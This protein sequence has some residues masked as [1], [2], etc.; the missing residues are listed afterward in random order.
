MFQPA[1]DPYVCG[2]GVTAASSGHNFGRVAVTA[3]IVREERHV[4]AR[5]V[6][7]SIPLPAPSNDLSQTRQRADDTAAPTALLQADGPRGKDGQQIPGP[8]TQPAPLPPDSQDVDVPAPLDDE[9]D[10]LPMGGGAASASRIHGALSLTSKA[11]EEAT[12]PDKKEDFGL[13]TFSVLPLSHIKI[14][15]AK[16]AFSVKAVVEM[17]IKIQVRASKGPDGQTDIE[18]DADPAINRDNYTAVAWD[19][20]PY[21][22]NPKG[23]SPCTHFWARDLTL[24]HERFHATED[25]KFAREGTSQTQSWLN[26]QT[27][28]DSDAVT[29]LLNQAPDMVNR[30]VMSNMAEREQRAYANGAAEYQA[31]ADA[32]KAKGDSGKYLPPSP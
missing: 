21:H 1:R 24:K 5:E 6:A 18:S 13:T 8:T 15:R 11:T 9:T 3:P 16:G 23:P 4:L 27:A 32:I 2:A 31:R 12:D 7:V 20:A 10:T 29:S 19:L 25:E 14:A 30:Y 22:N 28:K 17:T 26:H